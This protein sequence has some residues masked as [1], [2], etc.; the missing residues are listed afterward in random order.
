M[1]KPNLYQIAQ[2]VTD[3]VFGP[4]AYEAVNGFNPAIGET[5]ATPWTNAIDPHTI[6]DDVLMSERARRNNARRR[7]K[8]GGRP[9]LPRCACGAMTRNAAA[10]TA[11]VCK[12][13]LGERIV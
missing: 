7:T 5:H 1:K 6:P 10:K 9:A 4:G 2:D 11:H 8:A 3:E 12:D 13:S